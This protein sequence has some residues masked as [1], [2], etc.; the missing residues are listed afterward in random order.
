VCVGE[1]VAE[2]LAGCLKTRLIWDR[3]EVWLGSSGR[4][5][6]STVPTRHG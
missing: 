3:K 4:G 1:R 6:P 5:S 2:V